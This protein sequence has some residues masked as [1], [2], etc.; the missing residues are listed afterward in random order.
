MKKRRIGTKLLSLFLSA[1][2]MFG[3]FPIALAADDAIVTKWPTAANVIEYGQKDFE[4]GLNDD[5]EATVE[6]K[7]E[8]ASQTARPTSIG[9]FARNINY[10]PN[11]SKIDP[12]PG[13]V[14]V[15]VVQSKSGELVGGFPTASAIKAGQKLSESVITKTGIKL[16]SHSFTT[17][18]LKIIWKTPDKV[19]DKA[20]EYK[21]IA[22]CMPSSSTL[23]KYIATF[24][25]ELSVI[26]EGSAEELVE[27]KALPKASDIKVG[28][29]LA[30]SDLTGGLVTKGENTVAGK[31]VWKDPSIAPTNA[32]TAEYTAV[33]TPDDP[34][35]CEPIE[36][37]VS[38][39]IGKGAPEI[40]TWPEVKGQ[41]KVGGYVDKNVTLIGGSCNIEGKFGI[42]L[43]DQSKKI[44]ESITET[45][46]I[47][48]FFKPADTRN[49]ETVYKT[50]EVKFDPADPACGV[51][52]RSSSDS[53]TFTI[54]AYLDNEE[55]WEKK[56]GNFYLYLDGQQIEV[57]K[58]RQSF[59][60]DWA[61]LGA[62]EHTVYTEYVA[63]ENDVYVS[64]KCEPETFVTDAFY[65]VNVTDYN[66]T[67][68]IGSYLPGKTVTV[69]AAPH[70]KSYYDFTGWTA[71]GVTLTEEELAQQTVTFAVPEND[72]TL[73]A[74]YKFNFCNFVKAV[75]EKI[76]QVLLGIITQ[77]IAWLKDV[78]G[79]AI[80]GI[81]R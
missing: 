76:G 67:N 19:L 79:G 25:I 71:E 26:V 78:I 75:F 48:I 53:R 66:G 59:E 62:G 72:V 17:S 63:G 8:Y 2:M 1:F 68:T 5:G 15:T 80:D 73:T 32:I 54:Y 44:P 4:A 33:F 31:F 41:Y 30:D 81:P 51:E 12:I 49:Y 18:S 10:I 16:Q 14:D 20:G 37:Q 27:I 50:V 56:T 65:T 24:E 9:T 11:D 29:T 57:T 47:E 21:E 13:T 38:V 64:G 40:T 55:N 7:F 34:T 6:G 60:Y 45:L 69:T 77:G 58:A 35:A 70:E 61:T 3:A 39:T 36:T 28:Q 42:K 74:N 43:E 46:D 52:P 22:L 23:Q